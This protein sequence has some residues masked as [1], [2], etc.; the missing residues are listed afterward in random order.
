MEVNIP[1]SSLTGVRDSGWLA[2]LL[3]RGR[4]FD[5]PFLANSALVPSF[6]EEMSHQIP[7]TRGHVLIPEIFRS[8]SLPQ[9]PFTFKP[10]RLEVVKEAVMAEGLTEYS[11][12]ILSRC[13]RLDMQAVSECL[14][15][16]FRFF[17]ERR[18]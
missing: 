2:E 1:L 14:D 5:S 17:R 9:Q 3:R 18:N 10:S 12:H 6:I 8:G 16:V 11:A 4:L 7:V 15:K 13:H